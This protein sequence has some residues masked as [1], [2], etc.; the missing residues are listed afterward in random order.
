MQDVGG[1]SH[2]GQTTLEVNGEMCRIPPFDY[3]VN[4]DIGGIGV[5][6]TLLPQVFAH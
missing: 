1:C 5:G 4:S 2:N 6:K 3:K